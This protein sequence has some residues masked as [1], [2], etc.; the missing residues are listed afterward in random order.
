MEH[1]FDKKEFGNRLKSIIERFD[2]STRM[3]EQRIGAGNGTLS[4]AIRGDSDLS[5][6][7]V[8]RIIYT[9]NISPDWLYTGE[10]PM[11]KDDLPAP[12]AVAAKGGVPLVGVEA[13]AGLGSATFSISEDDI[14]DRYQVPDFKQVDFMLRLNGDSMAPTYNGG[15]VVGCL[16]IKDSRFIQW[17]RV[18]LLATRHQGLLV[19]R[20]RRGSSDATLSCVSDNAAYDPFE[21]DRTEI[22]GMALVVGTI[23]LE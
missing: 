2:I 4:R 15:D 14:L 3:A 21:I 22:T 8:S 18:Y 1:I 13:V 11:L 7:W 6:K 20:I 23:R 19:K 16:D 12:G 17:G 9:F 10:G 5:T